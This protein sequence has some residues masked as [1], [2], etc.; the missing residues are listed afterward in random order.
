MLFGR[1]DMEFPILK[2]NV[3]M[4]V[5]HEQEQEAEKDAALSKIKHSNI[6]G[7]NRKNQDLDDKGKKFISNSEK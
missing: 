7:I 4:L 6:L 2:R 1:E 3:E 5:I